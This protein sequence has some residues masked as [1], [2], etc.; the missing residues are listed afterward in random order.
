MI[1]IRHQGVALVEKR[2][3]FHGNDIKMFP[4]LVESSIHYSPATH[5][6]HQ[7][8]ISKYLV[9]G[10]EKPPFLGTQQPSLVK[11][12]QGSLSKS[13]KLVPEIKVQTI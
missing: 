2:P 1:D 6:P 3:G 11:L 7:Q 5:A 12:S 8:N 13:R 10:L 9:V 4:H